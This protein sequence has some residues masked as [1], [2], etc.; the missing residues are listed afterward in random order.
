[1]KEFKTLELIAAT[2]SKNDKIRLLKENE[3]PDLKK[4]LNYTYDRYK[5]YRVN[6]VD[7]PE[8]YNIIQ[9]EMGN[10]LFN[11]LDLLREHKTGS[12]DAKKLIKST[13]SKCTEA[14]A[15]WIERVFKRNLDI[16]MD[17]K[18]INKAFPDLIPVFDVQL[19]FP[20]DEHWDSIVYPVILDPKLDGMRVITI[21]KDDKVSFLSREGMEF[22][23][24]QAFAEE[25]KS[26]RPGTNFVL[27]GEI[28]GGKLNPNCKKAV[29]KVKANKP[30]KFTQASSMVKDSK[31][32]P[33]EMRK[34][35]EYIVWDIIELDYFESQGKRGT[36]EEC[37]ERR[38]KLAALFE[39]IGEREFKNVKYLENVV[40]FSR[41]EIITYRDKCI[42]EGFEGCMI[43]AVAGSYDFKRSKSVLKFKEFHTGDFR[44]KVA[45]EGTG[46]YEGMLGAVKVEAPGVDS[47]IGTG[48]TDD[49]RADLWVEWLAGRLTGQIIEAL[50]QEI[51]SEGAL[52]FS[53]FLRMRPDKSE[54]SLY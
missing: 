52:R 48:F 15:K 49:E 22:I 53:S 11:L 18:S 35:L 16:G 29:E 26:I 40:A 39:R 45:I 51:T 10:E 19:A 2:P 34:Y 50:Y 54:P 20:I 42:A 12:N 47:E 27:D 7:K 33:Q 36:N 23:N 13:M 31:T 41:E 28:Y 44:I 9:P 3:T 14:G 21:V 43:K 17:E 30:Y 1:M 32:T 8:T 5:T 24:M 46:K 4:L 37:G 25:V 6:K 38:L